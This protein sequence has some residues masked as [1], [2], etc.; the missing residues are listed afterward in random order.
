[1][2]GYVTI[3][4]N[5]IHA[6]RRYYAALLGSIGGTELMRLEENG[7]TMYGTGWEAPSIAITTPY[8]GNAAVPGNGQMVALVMD[9]RAKVDSL[10][11]TALELGG[12]DEGAPGLRGPAELNFYAGYFRDPEGNKLAAFCTAPE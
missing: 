11:A 4:T 2:I 12:S 8:D 7:M 3:G 6:A 1:M 10:H 9:S 5:D